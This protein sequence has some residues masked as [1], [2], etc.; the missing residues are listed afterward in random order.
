M[1]SEKWAS[2]FSSALLKNICLAG[3]GPTPPWRDRFAPML[4]V[5]RLATAFVEAPVEPRR[6][7]GIDAA[8]ARACLEK[9]MLL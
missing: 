4:H 3:I 6:R 7:D 1:K 8:F 9:S 2:R 5:H